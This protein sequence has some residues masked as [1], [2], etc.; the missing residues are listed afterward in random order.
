MGGT[1]YRSSHT[2]GFVADIWVCATSV[3]VNM[4]VLRHAVVRFALTSQQEAVITFIAG[5]DVDL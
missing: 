1:G 2:M 3:L 5:L 4:C